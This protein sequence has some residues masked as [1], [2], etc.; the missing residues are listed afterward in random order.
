MRP[1]TVQLYLWNGIACPGGRRS[2]SR[3][4]G[5]PARPRLR[6]VYRQARRRDEALLDVPLEV[7]RRPLG[8]VAVAGPARELDR[9]DLAGMA[10]LSQPAQLVVFSDVAVLVQPDRGPP[11]G[12]TAEMPGG[13][14]LYALRVEADERRLAVVVQLADAHPLPEPASPAPWPAGVRDQLLAL[15]QHRRPGLEHLDRGVCGRGREEQRGLPVHRLS[16][17]LAAALEQVVVEGTAVAIPAVDAG[18]H[19]HAGEA[20][21]PSRQRRR[22]RAEDGWRAVPA[23]HGADVDRGR[24]AAVEDRALGRADVDGPEVAGVGGD[25]GRQHAL[26]GVGGVRGRVAVG[27]VDASAIDLRRR[28]R[29]VDVELVLADLDPHREPQLAVDRLELDLVRVDAV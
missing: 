23:G 3:S 22:Q 1:V 21:D 10:E 13:A 20:L 15:D 25:L 11:P 9:Q 28:P 2:G 26:Q 19:R 16:R 18:S 14:D 29:P 17:P 4:R 24:M 8:G 6:A 12:A 7:S 27:A 5:L